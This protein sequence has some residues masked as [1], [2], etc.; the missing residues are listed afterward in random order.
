MTVRRIVYLTALLGCVVF[1]WAYREWLSWFLLMLILLLPWF[2]LLVSL[3]AL[4]TCRAEVSCPS[5]VERGAEVSLLWQGTSPFPLPSLTGRLTVRNRLC[6][7]TKKLRSGDRLPTEH[8]GL[9]HIALRCPRCHDYLGLFSLPIRRQSQAQV[10]VRPVAAAP[11]EVP[12][13]SRYQV[14][15][16]R[17]KPG[18]GFSEL[19]DLRLYRPGDDLRQIHWKMSAKTGKLIYREP[20]EPVQKGYLLTVTL[21]GSP[22]ELDAKLGKLLWLSKAL[23]EKQLPHQVR[24]MTGNGVTE[25]TIQDEAALDSCMQALLSSPP[26]RA[27]QLLQAE[28]AAWQHHIGGGEHEA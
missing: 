1:Y 26:A 6:G 19:H 18:G 20:L 22:K 2:S 24:C 16:W 23:L 9:L 17:P 8:C 25:F 14:N 7:S 5:A 12:D 4:L 13:M 28:Q 21:S 27:E 15:L 3:P 10:L 11:A